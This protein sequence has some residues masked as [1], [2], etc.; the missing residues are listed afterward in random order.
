VDYGKLLSR[1]WNIIWEHKF[2]IL[3]GVLVALGGTGGGGNINVSLPRGD[4][5]EFDFR[6]PHP[7]ELGLPT[8]VLIGAVIVLIGIALVIGIVLWAVSS[9]SPG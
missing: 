8:G 6:L 9:S 1:A 5:Q 2:L 3:L 7:E 4:V